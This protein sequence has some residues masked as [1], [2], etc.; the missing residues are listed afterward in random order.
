[1][2][3]Q[4]CRCV[5]VCT[6]TTVYV[7]IHAWASPVLLRVQWVFGVCVLL[8]RQQVLGSSC[9]T[10]LSQSWSTPVNASP[11][12]CD[13][14]GFVFCTPQ[15]TCFFGIDHLR[16][17][18]DVDEKRES[19]SSDSLLHTPQFLEICL[20]LFPVVQA[21]LKSLSFE[22]RPSLWREIFHELIS[23]NESGNTFSSCWRGKRLQKRRKLPCSAVHKRWFQAVVD[24]E[25]CVWMCR[26]TRVDQVAFQDEP[27]GVKRHWFGRSSTAMHRIC[28]VGPPMFW[29]WTQDSYLPLPERRGWR[30]CGRRGDC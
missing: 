18:N 26:S 21:S 10:K 6:F 11:C 27:L 8:W 20:L 24:M 7:F 29:V 28:L 1:M 22:F 13:A 2:C 19:S 30:G 17:R 15:T 23:T 14:R 5:C 3:M 4:A 25:W 16:W 9:G 12:A